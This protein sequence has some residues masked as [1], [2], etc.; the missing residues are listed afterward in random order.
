MPAAPRPFAPLPDSAPHRPGR[1]ADRNAPGGAVRP[2]LHPLVRVLAAAVGAAA[3]LGPLTACAPL[4]VGGAVIGGGLVISDR[5]TAATQLEDKNIEFRTAAR[6]REL[7]TE[8][9][10]EATSYNRIVLLSGEVPSERDKSMIQQAVAGI[11]N[12]R[13][14]INELAIGPNSGVRG[15]SSDTVLGT[16]VRATLVDARDLQANAFKVATARG[17]VYLMGRVTEAEAARAVE[18]VRSIAGVAQVVPAYEIITDD[19]RA[20]ITRVTAPPPPAPP[21]PPPAPPPPAPPTPAPVAPPAVPVPTNPPPV[22]VSPPAPAPT[23]APAPAPM[24]R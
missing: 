6:V 15:R 12:V 13:A 21:P 1:P 3:L 2:A 7:G 16:K 22:T 14:V 17:I 20:G 19:E 10:V 23:P 24:Q 18:L 5:R 8:G 9:N 11:E 4:L